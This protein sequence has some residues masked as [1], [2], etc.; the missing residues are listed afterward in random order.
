MYYLCM[1]CPTAIAAVPHEIKTS[2]ETLNSTSHRGSVRGGVVGN[3]NNVSLTPRSP[4][5]ESCDSPYTKQR[6]ESVT[7]SDGSRSDIQVHQ[8]YY[9]HYTYSHSPGP[10]VNI[11]PPLKLPHGDVSVLEEQ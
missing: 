6:F 4:T 2:A 9:R 7:D 5:I 3:Y 1:T 11:P 8:P 10:V